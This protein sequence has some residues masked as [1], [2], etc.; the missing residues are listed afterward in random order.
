MSR[1]LSPSLILAMICGFS[2]AGLADS[3][4]APPAGAGG[5]QAAAGADHAALPPGYLPRETLPDSF[6][7]L[8]PPPALGS[9]AMA[10][11]EAARTDAQRYRGTGRYAQAA[12]DAQLT[13]PAVAQDF[14]CALGV[15]ISQAATPR[16]YG[17]MGRMMIDVGLSTYAAK[18]RYRRTRPF[19]AHGAVATCSPKDDAAL[20]NDGSYPSGH[21]A[22]GWSWGLVLAEIAPDRA[23]VVLRRG[24]DFGQSRLIC[25]AHWQSDIDAG[26]VIAAATVARL[27]ADPAFRADVAAAAAEVA[28]GRRAGPSP[29]R[30][31]RAEADALAVA[32]RG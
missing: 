18:D 12:V 28:A 30:D 14:S 11:D 25:D 4:A 1:A 7:L 22:L 8:P 32:A 15:E 2:F 20:R 17:L 19:V 29:A 23:D 13:V 10:S 6:A 9:A 5:A 3:I 16:L 27:H 26:R 31:C 24:R 21:S